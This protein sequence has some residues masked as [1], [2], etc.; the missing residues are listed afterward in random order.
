MSTTEQRDLFASAVLAAVGARASRLGASD[1][2]TGF[3]AM[4][5]DLYDRELMV[6]GRA[7][8]GWSPSILPSELEIAESADGFA[9]EVLASVVADGT[10]PMLWVTELWGATNRSYNT[11]KSAFWRSIR[12]VIEQLGIADVREDD[13]PSHLVWSNLYK[14]SPAE[15]GNPSAYLGRIQ[16]PG[17]IEL[18]QLE[19]ATYRPLRLLFL[20]G[21]DWADPFLVDLGGEWQTRHGFSQVDRLGIIS[22]SGE[23]VQCVVAK[24]PQGKPEALWVDEVVTAFGILRDL[25]PKY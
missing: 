22:I 16:L 10:C 7:V 13:W 18:L 9:D 19:L 4:A 15:H 1:S 2:V 21:A 25:A 5:G 24:H 8:N 12:G 6:V 17:C 23:S 11:R 20:T 14:V 3:L